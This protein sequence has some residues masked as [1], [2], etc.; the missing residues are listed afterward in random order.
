MRSPLVDDGKVVVWGTGTPRREFLYV[1]D[2][3][4]GC[5][6]VM[7]LNETTLAAELCSYPKPNFVNLGSGVDVTIGQL[8]ETV[9]EAVGFQGGLT[10][11]S[12]K[13]D[14]TP[15]KLL[16]VSRM[17]ALGWQAKV[18]LREGLERTYAWYLEN[19]LALR[20]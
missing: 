14:G 17:K 15:R 2:M 7:E 20:D 10:F 11:D 9:R 1:D 6:F 5:V 13:P 16:D 4:D 3:A 8:A 18:G 12:S 19:Q